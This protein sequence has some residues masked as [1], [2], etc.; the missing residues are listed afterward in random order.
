MR[1]LLS[2]PAAVMAAVAGIP[3][4][5]GIRTSISTTSG[6]RADAMRDAGR[7]VAGLAD[8]LDVRLGLQDQPEAHPEQ[9]LVVD[10]QDPD[11]AASP[12]SSCSRAETCQP[13]GSRGPACT[14]PP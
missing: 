10:Q 3:S 5:P 14:S 1:T 9:G 2:G 13:P 7:P 11:H 6:C 8:H 4:M 12:A